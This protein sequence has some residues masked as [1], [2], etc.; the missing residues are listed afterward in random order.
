MKKHILCISMCLPHSVANQ[1]GA[2]AAN[3]YIDSMAAEKDF[4]VTLITKLLSAEKKYIGQL[5]KNVNYRFVINERKGLKEILDRVKSVNSKFNPFYKYGNVLR[6][7][8][9]DDIGTHLLKLKKNGYKPDVIITIWTQMSLYID[10]I[11]KVFPDTP[12]MAIE[13]DVAFQV[14]QRK[15]EYC[16]NILKKLYCKLQYITMKKQ[17]VLADN[18]FDI[19]YAH[20]K[21]DVK[22]LLDAGVTSRIKVI[23]AFYEHSEVKRQP[24]KKD[25]L[26]WGSMSRPEN[27]LSAIWFIEN[28]M[29]KLE[30]L[31]I[32]FVVLGGNPDQS[33]L[34]Y[35]SEKIYIT[36][37]VDDPTPY[38]EQSVCLV[39][40]LVLGAG[41]KVKILEALNAGI[42][43]LTNEI[44]IEGIDAIN[45]KEYFH[46]EKTEEYVTVLRDIFYDKI[47]AQQIGENAKQ[48]MK[49]NY[50]L[51]LEMEKLVSDIRKLLKR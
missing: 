43:V 17:E 14:Y 37:F 22:L 41:V 31:D 51:N 28:V 10:E 6:E 49:K 29:P 4:Q 34:K 25:I 8:V 35:S 46:C 16:K 11:K 32:R 13:E 15:S 21:K 50:D 42:P 47:N 30:D 1:A 39:A 24:N 45:G 48:F 38:F 19:V 3:L 7:S 20:S 2:K 27:Y 5:N 9:Y 36:G 12:C 44:G 23:P 26:F 40:P 18:K 33:L